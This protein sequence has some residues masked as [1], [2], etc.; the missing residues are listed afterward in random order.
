VPI[1]FNDFVTTSSIGTWHSASTIP[2]NGAHTSGF[3]SA[4][5]IDFHT[6]PG[7]LV[8]VRRFCLGCVVYLPPI[9]LGSMAATRS[10]K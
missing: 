4:V 9:A 6:T 1:R 3:L 2:A 5:N 10:W 7:R 8:P